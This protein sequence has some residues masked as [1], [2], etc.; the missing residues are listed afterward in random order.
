[1]KNKD[2]MNKLQILSDKTI[3]LL[4]QVC[5]FVAFETLT[6][7]D[8]LDSVHYS[9]KEIYKNLIV[10][11]EEIKTL[12]EELDKSSYEPDELKKG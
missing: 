7:L 9:V 12:L 10:V 6:I 1:M 4:G 2:R 11:T 8:N 3:N 5:I